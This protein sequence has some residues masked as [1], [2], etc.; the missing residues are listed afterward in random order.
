MF[1]V[2]ANAVNTSF[3][4]T[5]DGKITS[6]RQDPDAYELPGFGLGGEAGLDDEG[7]SLNHS[8]FSMRVD[9]Q[10]LTAKLTTVIE[11][12]DGDIDAEL[13]EL[14][15]ES[16]GLGN[17]ITLRAGRYFSGIGY[18]NQQHIHSWDFSDA[19]LVYR[20]FWGKQYIDDGLR[21]SWVAPTDIFMELGLDALNGGEYPSGSHDWD[22]VDTHVV[23][24]NFGDDIDNSQSWQAGFSYYSA[25]VDD[26]LSGG[27]QHGG[28]GLAEIPSFTGDSDVIGLNFIYKW[29]PDGNY[30]NRNFKL[31]SELFL[32]DEDGDVTLKGSSPL[33]T[34]TYRGKQKGLYIQ[35]VYQFKPQ[36]RAGLRFDYLTSDNKGS[37]AE[38]LEE[39]SLDDEGINPKRF[40]VM[41]DY[42]PT[43]MSRWR[44]QFNR[45]ESYE[46]ED[47]QIMLQYVISLG[48]HGAHTF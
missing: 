4:L 30:R 5:L 28:G 6:Y 12:D 13:E 19:P 22:G 36:W 29:A 43:E 10:Y 1:S 17:G 8:E 3:G 37:D 34:T 42:A 46:R 32:R 31:Q 14:Y 18:L 2:D 7:F 39:A 47:N 24:A 15:L 41:L 48:A 25:N 45:D 27:H 20:G 21:L 9:A 35:G 44:L 23:F 38:V 11:E 33:E 16:V 40:G 26:R